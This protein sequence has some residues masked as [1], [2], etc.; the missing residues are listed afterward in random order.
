MEAVTQR[1]IEMATIVRKAPL[2]TLS[3]PR[4]IFLGV[5]GMTMFYIIWG[6]AKIIS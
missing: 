1:D 6:I 2:S 5:I 4:K 3:T